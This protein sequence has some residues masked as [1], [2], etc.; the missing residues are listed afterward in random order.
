MITQSDVDKLQQRLEDLRGTLNRQGPLLAERVDTLRRDA[1][2][3]LDESRGT[4]FE[5]AMQSVADLLDCL[6]RGLGAQDELNR[7][8]RV[9]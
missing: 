5:P 2:K 4:E 1:R 9:A 3:L 6:R 8:I 7:S